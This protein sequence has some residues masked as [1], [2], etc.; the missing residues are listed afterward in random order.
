MERKSFSTDEFAYLTENWT[1]EFDGPLD[2]PDKDDWELIPDATY[3]DTVDLD[4]N[5][6]SKVY[7]FRYRP[8]NTLWGVEYFTD[9]NGFDEDDLLILREVEA[10]PSIKYVLKYGQD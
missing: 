2:F 7:I 1:D 4:E 5:W 8:D 10:I 9:S 3:V 6:Y